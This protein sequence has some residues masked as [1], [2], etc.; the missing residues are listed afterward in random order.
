[1]SKAMNKKAHSSKL[2]PNALRW[3]CDP[4]ALGFTS[5]VDLSPSA[6]IVG[7][8]TARD[9]LEFGI[10]CQAPGQNVYVRGPSGTGRM[11]M[12][13][14]LLTTLKPD[15]QLQDRCYVHHFAKP[16]RPRLLSVPAGQARE[17]RRQVQELSHYIGEELP[18]ALDA[19]PLLAQRTAIQERIQRQVREITE[20]LEADLRKAGMA[21]VNL[22]SGSIAQTAI[23]PLVNG[24][25]VA[26]EQFH[27]LKAQGQV[28]PARVQQFERDYPQFQKRLHTL[29]RD[30]NLAYKAGAEEVQ[31]VNEHA[32]RSLLGTF[33]EAIKVA[34]PQAEVGEFLDE[35]IDDVVETRL[36]PAQQLP[37]P[38]LRYGINIINE[39]EPDASAPIIE[40]H[41]PNL[42]NLLGTVE[43]QWGPQGPLPADYRGI[44]AGSLLRADGG[45]LV[46]D[47]HD[48]LVEPGAW[49]ALTRTL[50]SGQLEI[51]PTELGWMRPQVMIKPQP[52]PISVRVIL[53]GDARTYYQLDAA[54]PD[55]SELFKV[56]ADFDH[57]LERN[58]DGLR[59]YA[60]VLAQLAKNEQ[61]PAFKADAVAALAEHGARIASKADKLSARFSRIADIAREAA[62][63]AQQSKAKAVARKQ[64]TQAIQRTKTRASLPA[65]KFQSLVNSGTIQIQ[66]TGAVI[67]QINGLAVINAGPVAYGFPARITAT[68]GAGRAG[69]I[70]IEGSA[71]LSGSIHTKGFQILGGLLRH[72]LQLDHPLA[73]SASI[74]FEQS[75]GGIDGDSASGAEMCCL[76]SALTGQPI[77][78]SLAMTGAIDQHGHVQAI[79]GVNEKI[80]GFFDAC[81]FSGLTGE[82]GVLIPQSNAEDLMLREDVVSACRKGQFHVYAVSTIHEALEIFTGMP[83]GQ[84]DTNGQYPPGTLLHEAVTRAQE[85]WRKTLASPR[86]LD[87]DDDE[88]PAT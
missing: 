22:Q 65:R 80:E 61:L 24:E 62:F 6:T 64:V 46:L 32:T 40:E 38:T 78:Q 19:E 35:I 54:D 44:H 17:L 60:G 8:D 67:G 75:Y 3:R 59:H 1:M 4:K 56:L 51:V 20:P 37:D 83:A 50:R 77:K 14:Q 63:L 48:L 74:A 45:Y 55:F 25:P 16:D 82:Q 33:T 11:T 85:F 88:E 49:R 87:D 69:L 13:R 71:S 12:V 18:K 72:L 2:K 73:F 86:N 39:H 58:E 76:L 43:M 7:Q 23:F 68:I 42:I 21:L 84:R 36:R 57:E 9:A 31:R 52:I 10:L 34:F 30:V 5:T 28:P 66:T 27:Q 41:T 70:N 29:G 53:I 26:P 15:T 47:V 81:A 79:G